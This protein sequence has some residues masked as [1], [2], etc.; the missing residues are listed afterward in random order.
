MILAKE[1]VSRPVKRFQKRL[2]G[3]ERAQAPAGQSEG[4]KFGEDEDGTVVVVDGVK[5]QRASEP[6]FD[7]L[8]IRAK[9]VSFARFQHQYL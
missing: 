5:L 4:L 8:G 6:F 1:P 9:P 2:D 3:E 7:F